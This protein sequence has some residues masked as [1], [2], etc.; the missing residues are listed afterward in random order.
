MSA[1]E[2]FTELRQRVE[3]AESEIKEAAAQNRAEL[4]AT[5]EQA[6]KAADDRAAELRAKAQDTS[7]KAEAHWNEVQG[8]W[9]QHVQRTRTRIQEKKTEH[10][11]HSAKRNAEWAEADALDAV[12]FAEAA[13]V[14]A[15]YAVLD[16]AVARKHA[17]ELA[18]SASRRSWRHRLT[19]NPPTRTAPRVLGRL[20]RQAHSFE[21]CQY[22]LPRAKPPKAISPTSVMIR[23]IKKLQTTIT[24]IPTMT[25]IPPSDIPA[26]PPR[27][28][29]SAIRFSFQVWSARRA[30]LNGTRRTR[31]M[32]SSDIARPVSRSG[33]P[34]RNPG[35]SADSG[36]LPPEAEAEGS[37]P[38]GRV[39][40]SP[41]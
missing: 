27:S 22:H 26:I 23:P 28:S 1:S 32:L 6:R 4:S 10:D 34:P 16:A 19:R 41:L 37:N 7:D 30:A 35:P 33:Y 18:A 40:L 11:I 24:T 15:E 13:A 8:S 36:Y 25:M 38:S 31:T 5:A 9:D 17:D 12:D 14:E 39:P 3:K 20:L 21:A 29:R 2:R